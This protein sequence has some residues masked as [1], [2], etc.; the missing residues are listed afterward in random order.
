MKRHVACTNMALGFVFLF[1]AAFSCG[2]SNSNRTGTTQT[3]R[4]DTDGGF[5][6]AVVEREVRARYASPADANH[7]A[8]T[9]DIQSIEVGDSHAWERGEI[10]GGRPGQTVYTARVRFIQKKHYTDSTQ[11]WAMNW[12]FDCINSSGRW[13]CEPGPELPRT[14]ERQP[15]EPAADRE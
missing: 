8:W 1:G 5:S 7:E 2:P 4:E 10:V 11:V 15:D 9:V 14:T 12:V 6:R 13:N 3:S